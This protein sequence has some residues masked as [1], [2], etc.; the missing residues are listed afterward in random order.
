M[1]ETE[2]GRGKSSLQEDC[3][4]VLIAIIEGLEDELVWP[5]EAERAQLAVAYDGIFRG[6]VGI[7]D[8]KEFQIKKYKDNVKERRSWSGKKKIDSYKMLS[9]MDHTGRFTLFA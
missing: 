2:V 1:R 8:V 7:G 4:H 5:D 6:C 9:V 3:E